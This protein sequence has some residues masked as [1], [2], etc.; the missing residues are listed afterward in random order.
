MNLIS[1]KNASI[2]YKRSAV[3]KDLNFD[4]TKDDFLGVIGPNGSGKTTLLKGLLGLVKPI[5][6]TVA[7]GRPNI[8]FGYVAQRQ[9]IDPIFPLTVKEVVSM[10]RFGKAGAGR[11]LGKQD[12][13]HVSRAMEITGI[14]PAAG[15]SFQ[16]LSGGQK[17]RALIARALASEAEILILDEPTNDLDIKAE[18]QIM[19]LINNIHE[20]DGVPIVI[21]S[22]LLHNIVNYAHRLGFVKDN[23]LIVRDINEAVSEQNLSGL[24]GE[25]LK[26]AEFFGKK[27]IIHYEPDN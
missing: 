26:I 14:E 18:A 27:S 4:V 2:G 17:Q 22:H 15:L 11:R 5:S 20:N 10:G 12:W 24:F 9:A 25:S 3:L 13:F 23:G 19:G 7:F 21:V 1:F 16:T 8:R 6:G